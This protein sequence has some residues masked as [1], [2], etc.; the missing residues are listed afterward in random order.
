MPV[1]ELGP[2]AFVAAD[3]GVDDM[4]A[5]K[6]KGRGRGRG[7][8]RRRVCHFN[9]VGRAACPRIHFNA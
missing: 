4:L 1:C 9:G 8:G 6:D 7:R 2:L 5:V 3:S